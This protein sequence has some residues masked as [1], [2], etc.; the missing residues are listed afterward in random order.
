[1][2][3]IAHF[4]VYKIMPVYKKMKYDL[5]LVL[6]VGISVIKTLCSLYEHSLSW[7]GVILHCISFV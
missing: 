2:Y 7:S 1:M 5:Y 4:D 6:D 3:Y